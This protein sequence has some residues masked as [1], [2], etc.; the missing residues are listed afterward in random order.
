[1]ANGNFAGGTG[2]AND[3][4]LIEDAWDLD[5]VRNDLSAHYKL[6]K[7]IN[8]DVSPFNTGAGWVPI[9]NSSD[10]FKGSFDGN[11]FIIKNLY[12][13]RASSS[14]QGLFGDA[15]GATIKNVGITD[16]NITCHS[17]SGCLAG[18]FDNLSVSN[19]YTSGKI[20]GHKIIGG[21]IGYLDA[22]SVFNCYSTA[23]VVGREK[24]GGLVG[25]FTGGAIYNS[26]STGKVSGGGSDVRGFVGD[27]YTASQRAYNSF[28]DIDTSGQTRSAP[29][30]GVGL[31]TEQMKDPQTFIDAGWD[32]EVL[33]DGTPVWILM[34]GE[35]PKLWFE[36]INAI[37]IQSNGAI[38][39]YQD[40]M[41]KLV[42]D[43]ISSLNKTMLLQHNLTLKEISTTSS[44]ICVL[45]DKSPYHNIYKSIVDK[46]KM[47]DVKSIIV[48]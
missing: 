17:H 3:P 34:P 5:A 1:M 40:N 42:S 25:Y 45:G 11:G 22:G 20:T 27:K 24:T 46:R 41:W 28:W 43:D 18:W 23:E 14:F 12:I 16:C 10:P 37:I 7:D 6:I 47:K 48:K 15:F 4:Y 31:N 21:L 35:Y 8:L 26:Y 19:C 9:G 29:H 2:T 30:C 44:V 32:K 33:D 39:T 13:N 36:S 38:Y